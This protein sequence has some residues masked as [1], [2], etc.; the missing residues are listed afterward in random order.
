[1][2]GWKEYITVLQ[3]SL[4]VFSQS[5]G[6]CWLS[7]SL[8]TPSSFNLV[9]EWLQ[10][11]GQ[12]D[13]VSVLKLLMII[14]FILSGNQALKPLN[15]A[16]LILF[17][18]QHIQTHK[19]CASSW[20]DENQWGFEKTC[21]L[22]SGP[23]LGSCKKLGCHKRIFWLHD[24]FLYTV[25]QR[26]ISCVCAVIT[27]KCCMSLF[28]PRNICWREPSVVVKRDQRP[29]WTSLW[30]SIEN[31]GFQ[32]WTLKNSR[33]FR[34]PEQ[35]HICFYYSYF[36]ITNFSITYLL[37]ATFGLCKCGVV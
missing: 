15:Y 24:S 8:F 28:L 37:R 13:A 22:K 25:L 1:M 31:K 27:C 36:C 12:R 2:G 5:T 30:S 6:K 34:I 26:G 32:R 19:Q 10:N 33:Y 29:L 16:H 11:S 14:S 3:N 18:Y 21:S 23:Y 20:G 35:I 4:E 17:E 7:L 9:G